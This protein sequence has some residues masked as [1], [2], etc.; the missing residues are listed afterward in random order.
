MPNSSNLPVSIQ[1]L[2]AKVKQRIRIKNL[3][4]GGWWLVLWFCL[5]TTL[6]FLLDLQFRFTEETFGIILSAFAIASIGLIILQIIVPQIRSIDNATLAALIEKIHPDYHERL[7]STVGLSENAGQKSGNPVFVEQVIAETVGRSENL[8]ISSVVSHRKQRILASMAICSIAIAMVPMFVTPTTYQ[9]FAKRYFLAWFADPALTIEVNPGNVAFA[10][11][12]PVT[13]TANLRLRDQRVRLPKEVQLVVTDKEGSKKI[14]AMK[15]SE[16][17]TYSYRMERITDSVDYRIRT[18]LAQSPSF[19]LHAVEPITLLPGQSSI[20]VTPPKYLNQEVH[21]KVLVKPLG[22]FAAFAFGD[23]A[24]E[25]TCQRTPKKL[26]LI[27]TPDNSLVSNTD[28]KTIRLPVDIAGNKGMKALPYLENGDYKFELEMVAEHGVTTRTILAERAT[29]DADLPP[30]FV[31]V[32][33]FVAKTVAVDG[34]KT[35]LDH[36]QGI[37]SDDNFLIAAT[38]Y[39]REGLSEVALEYRINDG[40][41]KKIE[42]AKPDGTTTAKVEHRFW[43]KDKTKLGDTLYFRIV[44]TDN[45]MIAKSSAVDPSGRSVPTENLQPQ[46]TAF[47]PAEGGSTWFVLKVQ[48]EQTPI[49]ERDLTN[50]HADI[51]KAIDNI[52]RQLELERDAMLRFDGQ[53]M[54]RDGLTGQEEKMLEKMREDNRFIKDDLEALAKKMNE[55]PELEKLAEMAD[56]LARQEIGNADDELRKAQSNQNQ[57]NSRQKNLEKTDLAWIKAMRKLDQ[58]DQ[59]NDKLAEQRQEQRKLAEL[60]DQES[61]LEKQVAKLQK[62]NLQDNPDMQKELERLQKEQEKIQNEVNKLA[63]E[64]ST[65]ANAKMA[66]QEKQAQELAK[67]AENLAAKQRALAKEAEKAKEQRKKL[68]LAAFARKQQVLT[69]LAHEMDKNT[70]PDASARQIAPLVTQPADQA[71]FSLRHEM[72]GQAMQ[73]QTAAANALE[74]LANQLDTSIDFTR[75]TKEIVNRLFQMQQQLEDKLLGEAEQVARKTPK[76]LFDAVKDIQNSQAQILKAMQKLTDTFSAEATKNLFKNALND[77]QLATRSLSQFNT[78]QAHAAME[79][80]R[81]SLQM[82]SQMAPT[83]I[84]NLPMPENNKPNEMVVKKANELRSLAKDQ[85]DLRDELRKALGELESGSAFKNDPNVT[86]LGKQ[87]DELNKEGE[88]LN[89]DLNKLAKA[90]RD[91]QAA[92]PAQK[93]MERGKEASNQMDQAKKESRD[94]NAAKMKA[95]ADKAATKL[96]EAARQAKQAAQKLAQMQQQGK[97]QNAKSQMAQEA[98]KQLQDSQKQMQMAQN[99]LGKGQAKSAQQAMQKAAQALRNA[100]QQSKQQMQNPSQQSQPD[101]KGKT[102]ANASQMPFRMPDLKKYGEDTKKYE[103]KTWGQLP[104]ELRT[105]IL[106]DMRGQYGDEYA[107]IIRRY[108]EQ[109]ADTKNRRGRR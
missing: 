89:Q 41:I 36:A 105:R 71:L 2:L 12:E 58:M 21:P 42:L 98:E 27:I 51:Q 103:G 67:S 32:P 65:F 99:Q 80:A 95:A 63:E 88:K 93:A 106:M 59:L 85:L 104:G 96:D 20:T 73:Q 44:A 54:G 10:V 8:G 68:I 15:K 45:R 1:S 33:G 66:R 72:A 11:G 5:A 24:L 23:I 100:A 29:I 40:E 25:L 91:N 109:I 94:G 48:N 108:F 101:G 75:D 97:G 46:V 31:A 14:L 22:N 16:G 17:N 76:E 64:S 39:D 56:K 13:I 3:S 60:A 90:N 84:P 62:Q 43:L 26:H 92:N 18:S 4:L 77:A 6:V 30:V 34:E 47:P 74:R 9:G 7:S 78:L 57:A 61:E 28:R 86:K 55:S 38:V 69:D 49:Q 37:R 81:K 50:Q 107:T 52:R 70:R 102:P 53:T 82:L 79:S 19:S 87:Q 83:N 35:S